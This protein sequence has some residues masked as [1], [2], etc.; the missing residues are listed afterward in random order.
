VASQFTRWKLIPARRR[1][2]LPSPLPLTTILDTLCHLDLPSPARRV[3]VSIAGLVPC[4]LR[5]VAHR[6]SL[7][8]PAKGKA[9]A[10][11]RS[12]T[13]RTLRSVLHALAVS[14]REPQRLDCIDVR[15]ESGRYDFGQ[16]WPY[17]FALGTEVTAAPRPFGMQQRARYAKFS[18]KLLRRRIAPACG[19]WGG[20][21]GTFEAVWGEAS[22][23][24]VIP[25]EPNL[26]RVQ[27]QQT[28]FHHS[29]RAHGYGVVS[30]A[31]WGR[32]LALNP[33]SPTSKRYVAAI[34]IVV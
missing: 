24:G 28:H 27:V 21:A 19:G 12:T 18:P 20:K 3:T 8:D 25:A 26:E 13:H 16:S 4:R 17:F 7:F 22:S 5:F 15:R 34:G 9:A 1:P 6:H 10:G 30:V 14:S 29:R 33:R 11:V 32:V 2:R 23:Y 31:V